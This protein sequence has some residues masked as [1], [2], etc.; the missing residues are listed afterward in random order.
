MGDENDIKINEP[1]DYT[2]QKD[3]AY[4]HSALLM[5]A[6]KRVSENRS[7]EMRDGYYNTK[8]DRMGNAHK[9]WIPDSR[10]E[11]IESVESLMMIQKRDI[12]KTILDSIKV[13]LDTL[14]KNYKD[15]WELEKKE[16]GTLHHQ[17]K[18]ELWNEGISLRE[19]LLS[20]EFFPYYRL[21][22]RDKV[23]AYTEIVSIIQVSI[24][25]SGDYQ[26]E[27]YEG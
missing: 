6:L 26:E 2:Q 5:A 20:T 8:F 16:W 17:K 23:E 21:F 19:N 24:K 10:A 9:V 18:Q 7:K 13:F 27:I 25:A 1:K 14:K 15:Y 4:S 22:L 12:D 3:I 11:F